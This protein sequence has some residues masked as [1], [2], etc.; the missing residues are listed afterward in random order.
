M[1][2]TWR[3][4]NQWGTTKLLLNPQ[5]D[6]ETVITAEDLQRLRSVCVG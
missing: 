3:L 5:S 2:G 4:E 1:K 6:A